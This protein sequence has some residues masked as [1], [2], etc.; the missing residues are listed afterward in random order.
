MKLVAAAWLLW[1]MQLISAQGM[2]NC[3]IH[4]E[5]TV[6]V[7]GGLKVILEFNHSFN[8]VLYEMEE[9]GKGDLANV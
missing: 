7:K 8:M 1:F 9:R 6:L 4:G 5:T 2:W 3:L